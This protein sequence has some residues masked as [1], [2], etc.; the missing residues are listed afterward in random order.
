MPKTFYN[1]YS[2]PADLFR[3]A[4]AVS[5]ETVSGRE[6][7]TSVLRDCEKSAAGEF[8]G[9][10]E[11][12]CRTFDEC[13]FKAGASLTDEIIDEICT[14][15]FSEMKWKF[16]QQLE[17]GDSVDVERYLAGQEKCWTGIRRKPKPRR[18]I[19]VYVNFGGNCDRSKQELSV[20]GAVGVTFAEIMESIGVAAEIWGVHFNYGLDVRG[21]DYVD[22]VRLKAQNEYSDLGLINF[23]LGDSGVFRNVVFRTWLAAADRN[24][25]DTAVGLG[26]SRLCT[27]STLGLTP[28]EMKS[29]VMV[30]QLFTV[31]SAKDWLAKT[32][33][34]PALLQPEAAE[35]V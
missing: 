8:Y 6:Y 4:K 13:A 1:V 25:L 28:G 34:D 2:S 21:N 17:E 24:G 12:T 20:A 27:L 29:A 19:R 31:E 35:M 7:S 32:L 14:T 33:S 10:W 18:T 3:A 22:M 15:D 30:P 9:S 23:M 5:P 16:M 26:Q 11:G